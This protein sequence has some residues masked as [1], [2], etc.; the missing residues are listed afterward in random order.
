MLNCKLIIAGNWKIWKT[1][2]ASTEQPPKSAFAE[3]EMITL[4]RLVLGESIKNGIIVG[5][6]EIRNGEQYLKVTS[7]NLGTK[8]LIDTYKA[9]KG[10]FS[11]LKKKS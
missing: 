7:I 11:G 10:L 8:I 4:Y 6:I 9:L 5:T 3:N 2:P 1:V